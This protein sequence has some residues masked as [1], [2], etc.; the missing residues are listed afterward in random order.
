[1]PF[2]RA[3]R[4]ACAP[5]RAWIV[6][7]PDDDLEPGLSRPAVWAPCDN[8]SHDTGPSSL[9]PPARRRSSGLACALLGAS[10]WLPAAAS[11]AGSSGTLA[12]PAAGPL[13]PAPP[14]LDDLM[15]RGAGESSLEL[16]IGLGALPGAR[17]TAAYAAGRVAVGVVFLES[18]GTG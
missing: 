13:R 15:G 10:A 1:M 17:E 9:L 6:A 2:M 7:R 18:D 14:V 3:R 4:A 16:P 8:R 5:A 11:A 12:Q